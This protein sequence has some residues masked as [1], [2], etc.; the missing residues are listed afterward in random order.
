VSVIDLA[1]VVDDGKQVVLV[2]ALGAWVSNHETRFSVSMQ[3]KVHCKRTAYQT[4]D[5]T[6][7]LGSFPALVILF[8][9]ASDVYGAMLIE[10]GNRIAA[11]ILRAEDLSFVLCSNR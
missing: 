11:S 5:R 3:A 9:M 8:F 10:A 7:P 2:H 1:F 6:N 4:Y